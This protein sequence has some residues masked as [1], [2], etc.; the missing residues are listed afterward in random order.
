MMPA[1]NDAKISYTAI[2]KKLKENGF[3]TTQ[4]SDGVLRVWKSL[5]ILGDIGYQGEF[6][7]NSD[8]LVDSHW[9]EQIE[10]VMQCIEAVKNN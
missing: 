3:D 5:K 2:K 7:C 8:D 9:R 1:N 6:Y 10:L 4:I